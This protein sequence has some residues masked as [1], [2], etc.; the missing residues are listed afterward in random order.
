M[1]IQKIQHYLQ[2]HRLDGWLLYDFNKMNPIAYSIAEIS[3]M[4]TRRWFC[5]IPAHG[6]VQWIIP[7][8]EQHIFTDKIGQKHIYQTWKQLWEKLA[9][10]LTT[11]H[12][13]AMEYSPNCAIPYVSRVDAGTVEL[14]QQMGVKVVTSS[15]L[16]QHFQALL[17]AAQ[18]DSHRQAVNGVYEAKNRALKYIQEQREKQVEVRE[19]QV[20]QFIMAVFK[21]LNLI[22]N[23]PPIVAVNANA[24]NPHYAPLEGQS[25]TIKYGD[26]VLLDIW[27]KLDQDRAIYA[28]I[29][30]MAYVGAEVPGNILE[31]WNVVREARDNAVRKVQSAFTTNRPIH[32]YEV[33]DASREVIQAAGYGEYFVHRTGHN[34]HEEDHGNGAHMDNFETHDERPIVPNTLFSIEPGIYLPDF[35]IRSEINVFI[36]PDQ[37][38]VITTLPQTGIE[39]I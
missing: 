23:H 28:D 31:I 9:D 15:H 35:G 29:T 19:W 20:Q 6:E 30:W 34:I 37:G 2:E 12:T 39:C 38:A 22:T 7:V 5:L 26:L 10:L 14:V 11:G 4:T 25:D 17:S 24:S 21:E 8:I 27:A 3:G 32:G 36:D 16:V 18:Y 33:D 1:D 13:I